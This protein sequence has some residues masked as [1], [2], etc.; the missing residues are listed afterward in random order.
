[1]RRMPRS[2]GPSRKNSH[3]TGPKNGGPSALEMK[4]KRGRNMANVTID[5][6]D[7]PFTALHRS[8]EE[9]SRDMRLAAAMLWYTQGL[10]SHGKA[11]EF[12]GISRLDFIDALAAAKL[13]AF[14]V[15]V[16]ELI[17]EVDRVTPADFEEQ[18]QKIGW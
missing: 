14:H 13:P 16:G 6:P 3:A 17:E 15:D 4:G 18:Y 8:P 12:A 5:I 11:A 7:D 9:L 10:I 2:G 1:M